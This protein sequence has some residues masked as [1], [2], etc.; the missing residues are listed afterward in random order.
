MARGG[1]ENRR[2][3]PA[4]RLL[5]AIPPDIDAIA[6]RVPAEPRMHL[7]MPHESELRVGNLRIPALQVPQAAFLKLIAETD[8]LGRRV[9]KVG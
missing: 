1:E 9:L 2:Y 4:P 8:Q 3:A 5:L 7:R 6:G